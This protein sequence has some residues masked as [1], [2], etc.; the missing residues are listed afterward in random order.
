M[1][2]EA[3][4]KSVRGL[5]GGACGAATSLGGEG[6]LVSTMTVFVRRGALSLDPAGLP[7]RF[8]AT[9]SSIVGDFLRI[10]VHVLEY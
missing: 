6:S 10:V 4:W 5:G 9:F 2:C 8:G 3:C 1:C 7:R